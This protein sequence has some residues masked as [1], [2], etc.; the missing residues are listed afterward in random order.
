MKIIRILCVGSLAASLLIGTA[1]AASGAEVIYSAEGRPLIESYDVSG[2]GDFDEING[3]A[4]RASFRHPSSIAVLPDGSIAVADSANHRIRL[5]KDGIVTVYAGTEVSIFSEDTGLPAGAFADGAKD[6]SFFNAPMGL[7]VDKAGNLYVAD[8]DNHAVRKVAMDGMVTTLAGSG[9]IGAQDGK[10]AEAS[11]YAPTD[12]AVAAD[13]TVYVADTLNHAI[14]KVDTSGHVT[15]LNALSERV[16]EVFPGVPEMTGDFK[17]GALKD[18]LFN[19]PSGLA[20]DAKGNLYVSDSGNQRIRYIDLAAGTVT[21][22]AGGGTYDKDALYAEGFYVNG[23]AADARFYSPKGIAADANGGLYI[24]DSLNHSIRYLKDGKVITVLGNEKGDYG[25]GNGVEDTA[26]VDLPFDVAVA[27]DGS[28]LIADTYNNKIRKVE[29]FKLPSGWAGTGQVNVLY[30]NEPVPFET[31]PVIRSDRTMVPVRAIAEA[32]DFEVS[33]EGNEIFLKGA[34]RTVR[35]TVG[36]LQVELTYL[37]TAITREIDAA[38][39]IEG[40]RTYVPVRFFAEEIGLDV[41]W[42]AETT[43]VILRDATQ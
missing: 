30:R 5:L 6:I 15:T 2:S 40:S 38:P 29:Y 19:E 31:L 42:H 35:L 8:R 3:D 28:L 17:D 26:R 14:R 43:T 32:L 39:F 37:G 11:F 9:L 18:A 22:A 25:S 4:A 34:G 41:E 24:A 33:Y 20:L 21:T 27:A 36:K 10:G 12:V 1:S 7:D 16:I 23:P 13:G